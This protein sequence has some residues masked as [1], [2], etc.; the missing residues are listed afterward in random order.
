MVLKEYCCAEVLSFIYFEC[1]QLL[2]IKKKQRSSE[3][4][5]CYIIQYVDIGIFSTAGIYWP[6]IW[7]FNDTLFTEEFT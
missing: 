3:I 6:V 7:L 5:R 4:N 2:Q 1:S